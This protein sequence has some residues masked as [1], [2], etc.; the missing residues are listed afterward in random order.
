MSYL[1]IARKFRPQSF[2]DVTGQEHVTKTLANAI[3]RNKVGHAYLFSGPR[4]V[5]KTS[6][7]RIF[8]K[9]LNCENGPTSAPCLKCS[10]CV[11]I[12]QG[13][14]LA[15]REIDG[16]S[17]NSVDNVR[18]LIES[19]RMLPPGGSRYKVYIIDEVH[20]LSPSAFNA[21]LK[22]LEEPPP[23][24]VFMLATTEPHKI[25]DTVISRCQR[26]DLRALTLVEVEKRLREV[27]TVEKIEIEDSAIRLLARLSEGS[28]RDSQSLLDRVQSYCEGKISG[29]DAGKV[30][31]VVSR[32]TLS[33][34]VEAI[35]Q[36]N[37][38]VALA[39]V[40]DAFSM[41]IDPAL[42]LREFVLLWRELLV[43]KSAGQEGLSRIGLNKDES[44]EL[45]EKVSP[46]EARDIQD[47]VTLARD[48]ADNAIRS[49]YPQY[50]IEALVVRMATREPV[51]DIAHLVSSLQSILKA[52]NT[53]VSE[54]ARQSAAVVKL[55]TKAETPRVQA[56]SA[57]QESVPAIERPAPVE[58][59]MI[60]GGALRWEDFV[61]AVK[62]AGST[63]LFEQLKR[64]SVSQYGA[65]VLKGSAPEFTVN[66]LTQSENRSK[67]EALLSKIT[68]IA[69]WKIELSTVGTK[70]APIEGSILHGE[71]KEAADMKREKERD[72]SAHP[73]LKSL[74]KVF[75]G[76]VIENIRIK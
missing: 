52:N 22:S 59:A 18:E 45:T 21:L 3:S 11:G 53:P 72:I 31:G 2:A 65:G 46:V 28:M 5:G 9:C 51:R 67:I 12:T 27:C 71:V 61:S 20:M 23:H 56:K 16:A 7:A 34:I 75:P 35:F 49:S 36:R 42:F 57:Q 55:E 63:V 39:A 76:S 14:N 70:G 38:A 8:S 6:I 13:T 60:R 50:A 4:G 1:V 58:A 62:S 32:E 64:V 19:F 24:T 17:H 29:E 69:A 74:Q 26:H 54:G 66:Y 68:G 47:L 48:G 33:R 41:G 25:P 43:A 15:V 37:P 30:L 73:K 40:G 10:Q 44:R